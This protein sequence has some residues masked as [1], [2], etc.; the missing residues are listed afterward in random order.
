MELVRR[1]KRVQDPC[2][3]KR[4]EKLSQTLKDWWAAKP[5]KQSMVKVISQDLAERAQ[6]AGLTMLLL[7]RRVCVCALYSMSH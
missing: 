7:R 2:P 6:G 5:Q 4:V 1:A 3:W